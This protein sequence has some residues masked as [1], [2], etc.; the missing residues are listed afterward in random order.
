MSTPLRGKR[1]HKRA[2][3]I[4]MCGILSGDRGTRVLS[5]EHQSV[6]HR[7]PRNMKKS[8]SASRVRDRTP[9]RSRTSDQ[10]GTY[11][12]S[13]PHTRRPA[14]AAH[15]T[16]RPALSS[17]AP[18]HPRHATARRSAR[19][20]DTAVSAWGA[21]GRFTVSR[22]KAGVRAERRAGATRRCDAT[23]ACPLTDRVDI[24]DNDA[25]DAQ[26]HPEP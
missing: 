14:P 6:A 8:L 17:P 26:R 5:N 2:G 3:R 7:S 23:V 25:S 20:R 13:A 9:T 19:P 10:T 11:A 16:P 24:V 12:E 18:L 22:Q 1:A 15:H 4:L 21:D